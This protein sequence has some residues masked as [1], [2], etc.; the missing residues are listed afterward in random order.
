MTTT[1]RRKRGDTTP[2]SFTLDNGGIP[3]DLTAATQVRIIARLRGAAAPKFTK[4]IAGPLGTDGVVVLTPAA[5]DVNAAGRYDLEFEITW[6]NAVIQTI[7][8]D[9]YDEFVIIPDL[10]GAA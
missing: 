1:Y 4:V 5:G 2:L 6:N 3:L 9:G 10:G 7:P 8:G